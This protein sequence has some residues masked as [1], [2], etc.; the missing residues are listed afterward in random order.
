MTALASYGW[1]LF[2]VLCGF[3]LAG[4]LNNGGDDE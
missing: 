1:W 4:V 2:G 3:C